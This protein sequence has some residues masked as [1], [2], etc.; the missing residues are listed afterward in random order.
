MPGKTA[1]FNPYK[2]T[3]TPVLLKNS[4]Q[5]VGNYQPL[6]YQKNAK[7][8]FLYDDIKGVYTQKE[9]GIKKITSLTDSTLNVLHELTPWGTLLETTERRSSYRSLTRRDAELEN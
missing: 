1:R 8:N 5:D 2:R 3:V 9:S 7:I 4:L 6:L